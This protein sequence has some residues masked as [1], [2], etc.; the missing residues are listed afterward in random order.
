MA[1]V[2]LRWNEDGERAL[3]KS[4][5]LRQVLDAAA[6]T[7]TAHAVPHS[8]VDTGRLINSMSH[9]IE[10]DGETLAAYLG[11]G[12]GDGVEPVWYSTYHWAGEAPPNGV[13]RTREI[14]RRIPHP[15]KPAP[16]RPY[17]KSLAELGIEFTIAPGGHQS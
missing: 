15:T 9:R 6:F 8:G 17:T 7:I 5:E 12:Q 3:F 4:A 1:A 16:T 11:S 14:R 2:E 10:W 13:P